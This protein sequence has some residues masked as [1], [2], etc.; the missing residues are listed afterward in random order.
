FAPLPTVLTGLGF[1]VVPA[2]GAWHDADAAGLR[3]GARSGVGGVRE[4]FRSALVV[5]EVSL[6][7]VLL[8]SAGLL[9]R[10]LVRVQGTDPG[11]RAEGGLTVE[12]ARHPARDESVARRH[13]F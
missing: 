6:S 5:A 3:E 8:I 2:L 4:R 10:A 7:V 9:I 12:A 11:F 1:G 13:Q